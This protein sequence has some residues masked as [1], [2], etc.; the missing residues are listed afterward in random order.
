MNTDKPKS[1]S[2]ESLESSTAPKDTVT[3]CA[4]WTKCPHAKCISESMNG[5][6]WECPVCHETWRVDYDDIR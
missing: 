6:R 1:T 4:N 5:E 3:K 2:P